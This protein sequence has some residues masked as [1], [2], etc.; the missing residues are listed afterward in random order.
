M[1][2]HNRDRREFHIIEAA[3]VHT[4]LVRRG[5]RSPEGLYATSRA[6]VILCVSR[7]PLVQ[8]QILLTG[9]QAK[10]VVL[11]AVEQRASSTAH[12]AIAYPYVIEVRVDLEP[13]FATVT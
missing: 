12:R 3:H 7:V 4:P 6:E 10:A 1:R 9:E 2:M 8:G 11:H 5:P 13:H